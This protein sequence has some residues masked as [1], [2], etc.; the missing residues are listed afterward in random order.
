MMNLSNFQLLKE[1]SDSY[2][3]GHPNGKA[4]V[5]GKKG[6][7]DKAHSVIKKMKTAHFDEGGEAS[8]A[9]DDSPQEVPSS[10]ASDT[11]QPVSSVQKGSDTNA[12]PQAIG[13]NSGLEQQVQGIQA[14]AEAQS[15]LGEKEGNLIGETLAKPA[16]NVTQNDIIQANQKKLGKLEQAYND[17][18]IDP[19]SYFAHQSTPSKI[20][21]AVGMLLSGA[22]SA[23]TGQPNYAMEAI[24]RAVE[25]DIDAQ[26]NDQSK[27]LNLWKMNQEALGSNLAANLATQNQ[28]YTG[29]KYRIDQA[30]SQ[31][32]GPFA[33]SQAL[34]AKGQIQQAID[35]NNALLGLHATLTGQAEPGT[36]AQFVAAKNAASVIS[37][38]MAKEIEPKYIPG[39]G[40]AKV[41]AKP[42]DLETFASLS[43]LDQQ[44]DRAKAFAAV[45]GAVLDPTSP[46][47]QQANDIQNGIQ[48]ELGKLM[49]LKRINEFEAKKYTD[50]VKNPGAIVGAKAQQ[51]FDDLK[52]DVA[53]HRNTEMNKLGVMPF[54]T[55]QMQQ[56]APTYKPGQ[57]VGVVGKGKFVVE[58]DGNTLRP[59][60]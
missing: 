42:E 3:V 4:I 17:K 7:S 8:V 28:M 27:R 56:Q 6:L 48:L 58:P 23:T 1:D 34:Q 18:V 41:P 21:S 11:S 49:G 54:K 59:I 45:N 15:W 35:R 10:Q 2:H 53:I 52:R 60:Q 14:A 44:L 24:N 29:L 46:K 31:F 57:V 13:S 22:G 51:S 16:M 33:Q 9:T 37:P 55:G 32:K 50:L 30:A 5:V 20:L 43:G 19:N 47:W 12:L 25:A 36:E 39:I 26:K 38:D 40:I